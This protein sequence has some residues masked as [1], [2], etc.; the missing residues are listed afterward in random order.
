MPML[1]A[2]L[3]ST[4]NGHTS[5]IYTLVGHNDDIY[6]TGGDGQVVKWPMEADG[7]GTLLARM[8]MQIFSMALLPQKQ[9]MLLGQMQGGI[10]VVDLL[11]KQET[12][13]LALH[14]HGVFDLLPVEG[15]FLA[16]GGD[17]VL[18]YWRTEDYSLG[19]TISLSDSSLRALALHPNGKVLAVGSSDNGIYLVSYPELEIMTRLGGHENSVFTV[20]FS[21]DGRYLL[22]GS[23]DAHFMV[24]DTLAAFQPIHR[25]P[26]HLFTVN[27]IVYRPDG[28]LFA[29][30]GRDKDVKIWDAETFQLLKVLDRHKF[31]GHINSVNRLHWG[32]DYLVS[33]SDDRTVKLWQVEI[34]NL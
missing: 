20:C 21:P 22:S 14:K 5:S 34:N 24:W 25:L 30:A 16:A 2:T 17:G 9:Q 18:S 8:G 29:T 7:L 10:H 19:K 23:R 12:R 15:H 28:K 31:A 32:N 6:T 3:F 4:L 27:H 33:V 11:A 1:N 26:A 13:H